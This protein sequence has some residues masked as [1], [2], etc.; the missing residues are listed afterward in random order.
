MSVVQESLR[1]STCHSYRKLDCPLSVGVDISTVS[2]H[3]QL[4]RIARPDDV[5]LVA[6]S[7]TLE[8]LI[9]TWRR[10]PN[11]DHQLNDS[12]HDNLNP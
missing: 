6:V 7:E 12:C 10:N 11:S 1:G 9:I 2:F 4:E 8:C 5:E 3:H